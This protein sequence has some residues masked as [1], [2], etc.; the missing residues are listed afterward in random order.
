LLFVFYKI[1][2]RVYFDGWYPQLAAASFAGALFGQLLSNVGVE[3]STDTASAKLIGVSFQVTPSMLVQGAASSFFVAAV[4]IAGLALAYFMEIERLSL[5]GV[6]NEGFSIPRPLVAL[7]FGVSVTSYL[8]ATLVD[9][10]G[11]Q[12]PH[13]G[14]QF[15]FLRS[16][17]FNYTPYSGYA[18]YLFFPFLLFV[19]FYLS[20]GKLDPSKRGLEGLFVSLFIGGILG[21]VLGASLEIYIRAMAAPQGR[22]S[23]F[24]GLGLSDLGYAGVGL[25]VALVGFAAVSLGYVRKLDAPIN[26]DATLAAGGLAALSILLI[27][28]IYLDLS[29]SSVSTITT[30]RT[31]VTTSQKLP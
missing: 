5:G 31:V 28:S 2:K 10:V 3:T 25:D 13:G 1:G 7:A 19:G 23:P 15:A 27:L 8:A 17:F 24:I 11:S 21:S 16:L 22:L 6:R 12:F 29:S 4:P 14:G 18:S 26:S 20:A 9:L 30:V